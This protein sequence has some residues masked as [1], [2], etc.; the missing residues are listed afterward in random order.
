MRGRCAQ[1]E[2]KTGAREYSTAIGTASIGELVRAI[3]R[4]PRL[5]FGTF[6]TP[7][8]EAPRLSERLGLRV[9]VKRDD[10]TGLALGG[11]KVRK[12]EF[13]IA[14]ALERGADTVITT[15]GSQ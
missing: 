8:D 1:S 5:H 7:L 3:E 4:K 15:G 6:P 13:L 11:N 12:L 2:G 9:L 14:D 10:L